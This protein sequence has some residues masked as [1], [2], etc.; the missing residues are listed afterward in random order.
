[1]ERG[2]WGVGKGN[3]LV[4]RKKG[5]WEWKEKW[6]GRREIGNGKAEWEWDRIMVNKGDWE[7]KR[8]NGTEEGRMGIK[9]GEW[10]RRKRS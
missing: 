2:E 4:Y 8:E 6:G 3:G 1:M 9:M 7:W 10:M 5:D